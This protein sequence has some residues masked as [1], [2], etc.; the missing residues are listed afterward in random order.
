LFATRW[1]CFGSTAAT[2][3]FS[4]PHMGGHLRHG[5]PVR[6]RH[7]HKQTDQIERNLCN[8][9][10]W[11]EASPCSF[12][13]AT[14]AACCARFAKRS[15]STRGN[16]TG[17]EQPKLCSSV[18]FGRALSLIHPHMRLDGRWR[19]WRVFGCRQL[20]AAT[21]AGLCLDLV[22]NGRRLIR[23][24]PERLLI[25]PVGRAHCRRQPSAR[26]AWLAHSGQL[27]RCWRSLAPQ[28]DPFVAGNY[29]IISEGLY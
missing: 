3:A 23:S 17:R 20:I 27:D 24:V 8:C 11:I 10:D 18:A 7:A 16:S 4:A 9:I 25:R 5:A 29:I 19:M 14:E 6:V 28:F 26:L 13:A 2:L 21:I 12:A 22:P 1:H 15:S